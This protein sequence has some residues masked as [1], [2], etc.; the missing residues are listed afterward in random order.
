MPHSKKVDAWFVTYDNPMKEVVPRIRE[1]ILAADTRN[2]PTIARAA[3]LIAA[4]IIA[5]AGTRNRQAPSQGAAAVCR[6]SAGDDACDL[7][8]AANCCPEDA[9]CMADAACK[10]ADDTLDACETK[11]EKDSSGLPE[12][13]D[14]FAETGLLAK[15]RA[16]C[17]RLTCRKEC[18]GSI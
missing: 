13:Y 12:C 11:A 2:E 5:C 8:T 16:D 7:C 1:L 18:L 9:A 15:K 14:A 4:S 17:I 10:S 6:T 3:V